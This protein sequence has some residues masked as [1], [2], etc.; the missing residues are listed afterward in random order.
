MTNYK[1]M[2]TIEEGFLEEMRAI[3]FTPEH[4]KALVENI[5]L[6]AELV[7]ALRKIVAF[8]RRPKVEVA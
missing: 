1:E 5:M 8:E 6:H 7:E 2:L 4:G 3:P